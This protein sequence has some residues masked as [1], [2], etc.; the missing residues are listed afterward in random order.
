MIELLSWI[1]LLSGGLFVVAGS[2]G[3]IR[4]PDVYTRL[5]SAGVTDTMGAGLILIGLMS[6]A[7]LSFATIKLAL[8]VLFMFFTTPAATHAV[9]KAAMHRSKHHA[10]IEPLLF[11]SGQ[12]DKT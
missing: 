1:L 4:L 3:L 12:Q 2:V 10:R 9:A 5:H 6:Q 11:E 7:G 8:I